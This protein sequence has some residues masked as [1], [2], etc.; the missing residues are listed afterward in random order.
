VICPVLEPFQGTWN[1]GW[2]ER[3][4]R[5]GVMRFEELLEVGRRGA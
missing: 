1:G 2:V 3:L 4:A 5:I